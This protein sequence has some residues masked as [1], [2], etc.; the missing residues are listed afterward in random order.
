MTNVV[1]NE[2]GGTGVYSYDGA[3]AECT[4]VTVTKCK[5]SGV[6]ASSGARIIL[7]GERTS[8]TENCRGDGEDDC[9]GLDS[10][11]DFALLYLIHPLTKER[12]SR[13][14]GGGGNWDEEG[15]EGIK[16]LGAPE[17]A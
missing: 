3:R 10:G 17:S 12:V 14:N 6:H 7:Q 1:V 2:C 8:V 11:E 5:G 13:N 4:N 15:G 9:Y 16:E